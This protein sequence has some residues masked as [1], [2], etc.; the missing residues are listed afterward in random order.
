MH[1][2]HDEYCTVLVQVAAGLERERQRE[3]AR[4][5]E[6][7]AEDERAGASERAIAG[8][9]VLAATENEIFGERPILHEQ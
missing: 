3:A 9:E 4:Q 6:Q 2:L 8:R 7:R 5:L 1:T